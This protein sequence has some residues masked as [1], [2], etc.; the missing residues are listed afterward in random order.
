[1]NG[2]MR[3]SSLASRC[4]LE[5]ALFCPGINSGISLRQGRRFLCG[6]K[7]IPINTFARK[8]RAVS[9]PSRYARSLLFNSIC[10]L[11]R[12]WLINHRLSRCRHNKISPPQSDKLQRINRITDLPANSV[13]ALA[14]PVSSRIVWASAQTRHNIP[15]RRCKQWF[16]P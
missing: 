6:D 11:P 12:R 9:L 1:M 8:N 14:T 2:K 3:H 16:R 5:P 4:N 7:A 10:I 15:E 13:I